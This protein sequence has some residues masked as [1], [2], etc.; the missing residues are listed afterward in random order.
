MI[1]NTLL[2]PYHL[3]K[4]AYGKFSKLT[5]RTKIYMGL[6]AG[7][8]MLWPSYSRAPALRAENIHK[9]A[10]TDYVYMDISMDNRYLG[11][12][13]IGLYGR[14]LPLTVENF[15]HMCKGFHVKDKII[16]YYNTRFD[17]IVPGRA[18]LGGRLF[19]HKSSLDSCTIYSRRIP[20]ESFDTTF[21]QEGDVAMVSDGPLGV[22]SRFLI[23][24]TNNP[25]F[26]QKAV[27]VGTVVK[28][29]KLIRMVSHHGACSSPPGD[30]VI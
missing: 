24:L 30:L 8:L 28:G 4:F 20:E 3:F 10:I 12:I 18:I 23:T 26:Q 1:K 2:F 22:S 11:R 14:L 15:I 5:F 9:R 19:D 6:A 13:L 25:G 27:V 17:K 16:G 7:G 21:V 29:M